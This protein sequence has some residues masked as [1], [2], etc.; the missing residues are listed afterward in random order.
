MIEQ[1]LAIE[2]IPLVNDPEEFSSLKAYASYRIEQHFKAIESSD[3]IAD[4]QRAQG[5]IRELRRIFNLRDEVLADS[6]R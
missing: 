5:A 4:I 1:S 2:L 3:D 6:R